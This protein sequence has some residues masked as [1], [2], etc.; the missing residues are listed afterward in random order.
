[1]FWC[2]PV[3]ILDYNY[4]PTMM[5]IR[6]KVYLVVW[7]A[8]AGLVLLYV[9]SVGGAWAQESPSQAL[10]SLQI[11]GTV[12]L[13][14]TSATSEQSIFANDVIHTGANSA[15]VLTLPGTGMMT[16]GANT[17]I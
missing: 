12:S 5:P 3:R 13:N 4:A 1:M 8:L 15:A 14:G 9:C 17:E 10:G 11:S 16:I 7:R 6:S 2:I